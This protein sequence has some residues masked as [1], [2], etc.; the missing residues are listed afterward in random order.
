[1]AAAAGAGAHI[2]SINEMPLFKTTPNYGRVTDMELQK[3]DGYKTK[4][5]SF[6]KGERSYIIKS[7]SGQETEFIFV[8]AADVP[9]GLISE[10]TNH[11][12]ATKSRPIKRL[13]DGRLFSKHK[14]E[15]YGVGSHETVGHLI[16]I[17]PYIY[18]RHTFKNN[19]KK[20]GLYNY[21]RKPDEISRYIIGVY[22]KVEESRTEGGSWY[23]RTEGYTLI[24]N[25][26]Q[27][28]QSTYYHTG[29]SDSSHQTPFVY[30]FYDDTLYP[31]PLSD[32]QIDY[33]KSNYKASGGDLVSTP[34]SQIINTLDFIKLVN[35]I[36]AVCKPIRANNHANDPSR[37]GAAG[38]AE[39][40]TEP[41]KTVAAAASENTEPSRAAP[42]R[43]NTTR[44][45]LRPNNRRNM[46]VAAMMNTLKRRLGSKK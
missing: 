19:S 11:T 45:N 30:M 41:S 23:T 35:Q 25:H 3:R 46:S 6:R 40:N 4:A 28:Y 42:Q 22:F 2:N 1:M 13:S 16:P 27:E 44:H 5:G 38:A 36:P 43:R 20:S 26:G 34:P 31:R 17:G 12:N 18:N 9:E 14:S 15:V 32:I 21:S 39:E 29:T 8:N 33:I 37:S 10:Y 24:D 7:T